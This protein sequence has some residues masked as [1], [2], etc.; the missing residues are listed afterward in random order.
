MFVV[1]FF[2][3][4]FHVSCFESFNNMNVENCNINREAV[5]RDASCFTYHN[6]RVFEPWPPAG[7]GHFGLDPLVNREP[8]WDGVR[9]GQ[10]YQWH[11]LQREVKAAASA[12]FRL[13]R[14]STLMQFD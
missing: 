14:E 8:G 7:L 1:G 6:L 3:S 12:R 11:C 13:H 9:I 2:D 4:E 5:S 10:T